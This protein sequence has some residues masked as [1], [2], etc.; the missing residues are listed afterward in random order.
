MKPGK[1]DEL[2]AVSKL[3]KSLDVGFLLARRH[4]GCADAF[5]SAK[6]LMVKTQGWKEDYPSN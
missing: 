5:E 1:G 4:G 3:S 6:G 2:P